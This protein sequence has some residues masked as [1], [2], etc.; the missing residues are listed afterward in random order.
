MFCQFLLYSNVTNLYILYNL[1]NLYI[2]IIFLTFPSSKFHHKLLDRSS[3]HG[4]AVNE[5]D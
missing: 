3:H 2:Y 5:P 4:S 1:Y